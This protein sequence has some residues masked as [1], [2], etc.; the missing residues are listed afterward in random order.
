MKNH[1]KDARKK[2]KNKNLFKLFFSLI[3][4]ENEKVAPSCATF[5]LFPHSGE[6]VTQRPRY[7]F[8]YMISFTSFIVRGT[9][10]KAPATRL[11]A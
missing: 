5:V 10:G 6:R 7:F 3:G 2:T 4:A 1:D 11:G 8:R 9:S